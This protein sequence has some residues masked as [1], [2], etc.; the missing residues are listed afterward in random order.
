MNLQNYVAMSND[1]I[2]TTSLQVAKAFGKRH[3]HVL[4]SIQNLDCSPEFTSAHFWAHVERIKAGAVERDSKI[5][6][7]TKDG[8]MFLVMGFTG[9]KAASIKEAY[10]NAF[11]AMAEQLLTKD[12]N[13]PPAVIDDWEVTTINGKEVFIFTANNNIWIPENYLWRVL[14]YSSAVYL[15]KLYHCYR[16]LLPNGS[17]FDVVFDEEFGIG[18]IRN[19]HKISEQE[20]GALI[21]NLDAMLILATYSNV[22]NTLAVH[23]W[24]LNKA[25]TIPNGMKMINQDSVNCLVSYADLG[26]SIMLQ[27]ENGELTKKQMI[28]KMHDVVMDTAFITKA[29]SR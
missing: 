12:N 3:S 11:N 21:F 7:M 1:Q 25:R 8:F 17:V 28:T 13:I 27:A 10:I 4:R 9:K 5:Y 24:I 23:H 18:K 6:H 20:N 29:I 26:R 15:K 2:T 16:H 22:C 19:R 14:N